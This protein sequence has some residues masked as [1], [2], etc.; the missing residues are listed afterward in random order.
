MSTEPLNKDPLKKKDG[1]QKVKADGTPL[2]NS[3]LL[4]YVK[5]EIARKFRLAA[6]MPEPGDLVNEDN[7]DLKNVAY[8]MKKY[9]KFDKEKRKFCKYEYEQIKKD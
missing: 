8:Y 5:N 6:H 7:Y 3:D 2:K 1:T 4:M 9:K